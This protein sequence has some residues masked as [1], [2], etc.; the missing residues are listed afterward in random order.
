MRV[1]PAHHQRGRRLVPLVHHSHAVRADAPGDRRDEAGDVRRGEA[2]EDQVVHQSE[3][4]GVFLLGSVC[5][6]RRDEKQCSIRHNSNGATA[7]FRKMLN[8]H[9]SEIFTS[10]NS[11]KVCIGHKSEIKTRHNS[12][13]LN[14][15]YG[16][17]QWVV[18]S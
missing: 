16:L 11:E 2:E 13:K 14:P 4:A 7:Q 5:A 6:M 18:G 17:S 9:K 3:A 12:E 8:S 1:G 10:H 15:C